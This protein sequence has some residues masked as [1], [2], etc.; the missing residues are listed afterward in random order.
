LI[1]VDEEVAFEPTK[2]RFTDKQIKFNRLQNARCSFRLEAR[3]QLRYLG[4][5][6]LQQNPHTRSQ[7]VGIFQDLGLVRDGI[8]KSGGHCTGLLAPR[9]RSKVSA[10][11]ESVHPEIMTILDDMQLMFEYP[12]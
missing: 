5:A 3:T 11:H 7:M 4:T 9:V 12:V 2:H 6:F 8:Q 1:F 10:L